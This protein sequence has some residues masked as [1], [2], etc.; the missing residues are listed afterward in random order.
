MRKSL[1]I[2]AATVAF[3]LS[4]GLA[5]CGS[6]DD[7][8]DSDT[9]SK[10]ELIAKAD[11][12]CAK[13]QEQL[14]Q[15]FGQA[16]SDGDL[17]GPQ[18]LKFVTDTVL[19]SYEDE[20]QQLAELKPEES[21]ADAWNDILTKLNDAIATTKADPKGAL[22]N[23]NPFEDATQAAQDFGLTKCGSSS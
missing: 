22:G 23:G 21:E 15:E 2:G 8:S 3:A 5:A 12:I 6:S 4:L 13:G 16:A 10:S 14:D 18:L 11:E 19:P 17:Q 1:A 9:L 20:A 7:S